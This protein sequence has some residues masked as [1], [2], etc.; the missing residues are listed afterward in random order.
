MLRPRRWPDEAQFG[1]AGSTTLAPYRISRSVL[2]PR[3]WP[4]EAQFGM[5][6]STTLAPYRISRCEWGNAQLLVAH[7]SW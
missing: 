7:Y 3:R 2:R 6:A 5:A 4:D 1:M